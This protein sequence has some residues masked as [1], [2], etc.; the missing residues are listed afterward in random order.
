MTPGWLVVLVVALSSITATASIAA[1]L[2]ARRVRKQRAHILAMRPIA[3]AVYKGMMWCVVASIFQLAYMTTLYILRVNYTVTSRSDAPDWLQ[4]LSLGQYFVFYGE[5]LVPALFMIVIA[6]GI[7]EMPDHHG[8]FAHVPID[9][10][11]MTDVELREQHHEITSE[12]DKRVGI[13]QDIQDR[14]EAIADERERRA[15]LRED[16]QNT[17]EDEQNGHDEEKK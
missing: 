11:D 3:S 7:R 15:D 10:R 17:R 14:R 9:P 4:A 13:R 5:S 8:I 6:Y 16:K 2:F 12:E 1:W